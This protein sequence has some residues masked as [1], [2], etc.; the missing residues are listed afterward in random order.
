MKQKYIVPLIIFAIVAVGTVVV[1]PPPVFAQGASY[2][3]PGHQFNFNF[4]F[5]GQQRKIRNEAEYR[6]LIQD[7]IAYLREL[8]SQL[9]DLD[10]T[11]IN[12]TT[13]PA[14]AVTDASARLQGKI[15]D[16]GDSDFV[17]AWF[18]YGLSNQTL[19][20]KTSASRID[21]NDPGDFNRTIN[22]LR[23]DT[24]YYF[25]AIARDDSGK[26]DRGEILNFTTADTQSQDSPDVRTGIVTDITNSSA[27]L[28]GTIDMND[29]RNGH[30]FF[31]YGE[32]EERVREVEQKYT[33]YE[34]VDELG[35]DLQKISV[36][37]D[38]DDSG[39]YRERIIDLDANTEHAYSLCVAY[40]DENNDDTLSCGSIRNFTTAS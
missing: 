35:K 4:L 21:D 5:R 18:V 26:I 27:K 37:S 39:S 17:T 15:T 7:L 31:V 30:V 1:A 19:A 34:D 9:D 28:H 10:E 6:I 38:L 2:F 13:H 32:N 8:Q 22:N 14:T 40:T 29:F 16:F 11:S 3:A 23:D 24:R 12:V 20:Q 36:D 33:S 25:R